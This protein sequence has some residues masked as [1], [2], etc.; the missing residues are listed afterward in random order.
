MRAYIQEGHE[1][2]PNYMSLNRTAHAFWERGYEVVRFNY[3]QLD[4]GF[5]DRG[6]LKF[7]DETIVAGGVSTV[8]EALV[9]AGR[10]LPPMLDLPDELAPWIG[11]RW[12]ESTLGEV[13]ALVNNRSDQL[14]LHIKPFNRHKLF[15]GG[16]IRE[17]RDLIASN[18]IESDVPIL[19]QEYVDFV[20][21]W[22]ASVFRGR[23]VNVAHYLG[24]PL[25][26]PD[27]EVMQAAQDAFD[28]QPIACGIDWGITSTGQTLIVEVNDSFALGNYGVR[29][30]LHSVMI[31]TRWR[32]MMGLPDN[33]IGE[34]Y[35]W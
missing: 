33:G 9:R 13:R 2:D 24:D 29:D 27:V 3:P 21:E 23:I 25:R 11:R 34:R 32:E 35:F 7:P 19:V 31:E 28:N 14:P 4:E 16:V 1:G 15:K 10:P 8:R 20:S 26:F 5:L 12:W 6:L 22:R 18:A 17:F 30:Q